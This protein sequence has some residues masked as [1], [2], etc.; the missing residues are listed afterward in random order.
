MDLPLFTAFITLS[1]PRIQRTQRHRFEDIRSIAILAVIAGA[2]GWEDMETFGLAKHD[3]LASFLP[4]PKRGRSA[5]RGTPL[6]R[7]ARWR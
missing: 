5:L 4:L 6:T 7:P 2:E 1:D 3:W